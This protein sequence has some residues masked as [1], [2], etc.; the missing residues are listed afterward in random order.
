MTCLFVFGDYGNEILKDYDYPI[1][2]TC[3]ITCK[4]LGEG[5]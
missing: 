2:D 5:N 3:R 1:I 4:G